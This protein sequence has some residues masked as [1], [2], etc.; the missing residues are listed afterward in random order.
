MS[1]PQVAT[2]GLVF[3]LLAF[4]ASASAIGVVVYKN[5]KDTKNSK[6]TKSSSARMMMRPMYAQRMMHGM[7][8]GVGQASL[9]E[10][11]SELPPQPNFEAIPRVQVMT[12]AMA[13]PPVPRPVQSGVVGSFFEDELPQA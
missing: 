9:S 3:A 7:S 1:T 11:F 6:N 4:F 2:A 12:G 13:A 5:A 8:G 10:S